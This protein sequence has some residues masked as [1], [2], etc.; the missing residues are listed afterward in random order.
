MNELTETTM[1]AGLQAAQGR[2]LIG[3][4]NAD[5]STSTAVKTRK[6]NDERLISDAVAAHRSAAGRNSRRK[7]IRTAAVIHL[8]KDPANGTSPLIKRARRRSRIRGS[9]RSAQ[10]GSTVLGRPGAGLRL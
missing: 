7:T 4:T 6:G 5:I 2:G 10:I 8:I 1:A 9:L 3:R